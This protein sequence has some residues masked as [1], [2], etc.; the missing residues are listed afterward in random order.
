MLF[1]S[2]IEENTRFVNKLFLIENHNLI[3]YYNYYCISTFLFLYIF[4]LLKLK[5]LSQFT[6]I[7]FKETFV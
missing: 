6:F 2:F 3:Y 5:L 4:K 1:D 7:F